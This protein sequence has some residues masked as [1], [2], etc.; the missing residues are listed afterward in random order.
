MRLEIGKFFVKEMAFGEKTEF[1]NGILTICREEAISVVKE[2]NHVTEADLYIVRPGDEVRMVPV[3]E[4][5]EMRCKISGGVMFPGVTN[6]IAPAGS[7][8]THALKECS[9]IVVGRH[10][11][12][13][14]D[15][16]IDMSGKYQ[17]HTIYGAMKNLVL[18]ADTD[19]EFERHEQQKKNRALR[20]A[21]HRLAEHIGRCLAGL[22][23]EEIET[24]DLEPVNRRDPSVQGLPSVIYVLQLQTQ[25]EAMGYNTLLY[26][27]DGNHMLPTFLHP[28]E[29]LDGAVV[30]GSFMPVSSKISTYEHCNNPTIKKLMREHGKTV[31]FLGVVLSNLNVA[32]EQ[33]QRSAFMVAQMAKTL[34]ADGAIVAEEGYGNP[35]VDY[36]QTIVELEKAGVRTVGISNECT[37][38]DGRSQPLVALD[39]AADA[40]VSTG[41]VSQYY[42][43]PLMKTVLGDLASLSRDGISGGWE[44]CV[45]AD[46]SLVMENNGLFCADHVSG[47]SMKTCMDF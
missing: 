14:Q 3:K 34:G 9:L 25:M 37:G 30:S 6:A 1:R 15:G 21:G 12:C 36:I 46:G 38:R 47:F 16:L 10:W 8:R 44:G 28:N 7:G 18:V 5:I 11:G 20:W 19:E 4:A 40:L 35:D 32:M 33:K 17:R 31:N 23:P 45:R 26:G 29:I 24:W 2:D 43:L 22:E 39:P 27:W 13:F 41:N 42:E